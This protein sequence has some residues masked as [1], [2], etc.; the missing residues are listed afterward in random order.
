MNASIT[1][2]IAQS[3]N[4]LTVPAQAI[5]SE[6]L[7][8]FVEILREDGS[9]ERVEVQ[10]GLSDG[11]NTEITG[12]LEAG[13]VI[14]FSGRAATTVQPPVDTAFPGGFGGGGFG[15]GGFGGGGGGGFGGGGGGP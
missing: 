8:S 7:Q 13:D 12:E 11:I 5:Q 15:G 1:I 3:V 9:T 10:I 6:G 2:T 4:V 14:V